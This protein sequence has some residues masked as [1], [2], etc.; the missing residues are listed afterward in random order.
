MRS[1]RPP[2]GLKRLPYEAVVLELGLPSRPAGLPLGAPKRDKLHYARA[3]LL[4]QL[5]EPPSLAR[6]A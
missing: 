5:S 1:G 2:L 4:Q 3:L 6:L